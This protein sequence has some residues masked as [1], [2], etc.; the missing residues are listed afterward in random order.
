MFAY[1]TGC[2]IKTESIVREIFGKNF[3]P[4]IINSFP[5]I[6]FTRLVNRISIV[7]KVLISRVIPFWL[8]DASIL[9]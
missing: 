9:W 6:V 1:I 5:V 4:Y 7:I 8:P 3:F 2:G